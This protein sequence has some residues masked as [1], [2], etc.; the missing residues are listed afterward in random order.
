VAL[1]VEEE[2][3]GVAELLSYVLDELLPLLTSG[4]RVALDR[5]TAP[6]ERLT[7]WPLRESYTL[8]ALST[9]RV[10]DVAEELLPLTEEP[11]LDELRPE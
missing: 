11:L 8:P 2:R 4:E 10:L 6:L 9:I 7:A 1:R 5:E 3:D